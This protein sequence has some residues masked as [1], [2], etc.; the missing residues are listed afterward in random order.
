MERIC[1]KLCDRVMT[2]SEAASL[3]GP[4]SVVGCSGF[5]LVGEPKAVPSEIARIGKAK[6]MTL[7]TGASV[8]DDLDGVL[9]RAGMLD[10]R[11]P[12]QSNK[13]LRKEINSGNTG[14]ADMHLSHMPE[15]I[16]RGG[17]HIDW[18]IVEC[19]AVLDDGIVLSGSVGAS[20]AFIRNADRIILEVNETLPMSLAG[21]HD[22]GVNVR[23]PVMIRD[24]TDRIGDCLMPYDESR[25]AA[26][27]ITDDPGKYPVFKEADEDSQAIA[28]HIIKFLEGEIAAGRQTANLSPLQ[29]GVGNVANAVLAG[30]KKSSLTNLRMYTEVIQDSAMELLLDGRMSGASSTSV[31]LSSEMS[32]RFYENIDTLRNKFVLRPQRLSNHPEV[33]RRLGVIAMNTPI[34]FDIYGNVNSTHTMGTNMM[35]G[36]GGSGDFARNGGLTIFATPSVAKEGKISCVVPMCAHVD[37]TEHDVQVVVTEQGL[38]DLRWKSPRQRAELIIENCAH[39][40]YRPVLREYYKDACRFGGQTPQILSKAFSMHEKYIETGSML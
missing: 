18:A 28:D 2:A 16:E 22:L 17:L 9:A 39:P 37:H 20:D 10:M 14:Y 12:Y 25:I 5:T 38:A 13:S 11:Y 15:F 27:V 30:L 3:V 24:V 19:T 36:I 26:I 23:E 4:Y 1:E 6:H 29:S 21:V 32:E 35:N 40:D 34:E 33:V 31:S 8:G 7:L